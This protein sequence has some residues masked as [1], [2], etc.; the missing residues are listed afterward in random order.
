MFTNSLQLFA[1]QIAFRL[2]FGYGTR[3][4]L[5][6]CQSNQY[7]IFSDTFDL[8]PRNRNLGGFSKA[9]H[10]SL[11]R[12]DQGYDARIV[13][14]DLQITNLSQLLAGTQIDH[15]FFGKLRK[16]ANFHRHHSSLWEY[17]L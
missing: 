9:Q 7:R 12:Q 13:C 3:G 15:V 2:A 5:F 14:A 16:V 17:T 1:E 4:Q 11:A 6:A 8:P 10:G